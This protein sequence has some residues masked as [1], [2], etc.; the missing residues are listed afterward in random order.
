MDEF[1]VKKDDRGKAEFYLATVTSWYSSTN[2]AQIVLDG[3]D[4]AMTKKYKTICGA[5]AVSS[6]VVVMKMSGTFV[7]LGEIGG[8]GGSSTTYITTNISDIFS[9]ISSGFSVSEAVYVQN[10]KLAMFTALISSDSEGATFDWT[11][12]ATLKQGKRPAAIV[13]GNCQA[14]TYCIVTTGGAIQFSLKQSAN[15]NYR[16]SATFILA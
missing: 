10:G 16:V 6:R 5:V 11:T 12:W 2:E 8:D 3:D 14:T 13:V 7:I 15:A 1:L 4:S 9:S